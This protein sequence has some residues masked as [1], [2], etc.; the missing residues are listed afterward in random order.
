MEN[1]A[2]NTSN[3]AYWIFKH[4]FLRKAWLENYSE[5]QFQEKFH[6][7]LEFG[8]SAYP[9]GMAFVGVLISR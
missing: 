1:P 2:K 7:F 4:L 3:Q 6:T 5:A 8:F 9:L